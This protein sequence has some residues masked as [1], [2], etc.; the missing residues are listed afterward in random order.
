MQLIPNASETV[1]VKLAL[2]EFGRNQNT[3]FAEPW[4]L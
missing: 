2:K 1:E 4:I 3:V